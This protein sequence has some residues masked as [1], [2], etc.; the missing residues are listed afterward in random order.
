MKP[1]NLISAKT[2]N[3][4][5]DVSGRMF[6]LVMPLLWPF[7]VISEGGPPRSLSQAWTNASLSDTPLN[8]FTTL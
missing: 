8:F 3:Q 7:Y 1:G 5:G 6:C 4:L 2:E